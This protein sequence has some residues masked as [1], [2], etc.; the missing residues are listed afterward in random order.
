MKLV[1]ILI[2]TLFYSS[3]YGQTNLPAGK[4]SIGLSIDPAYS[5]RTLSKQ[6]DSS[7]ADIIYKSRN[8][9]EIA[10]PGYHFAITMRY[11]VNNILQ[12]ETGF[13]YANKGYRTKKQSTVFFPPDPGQP[14]YA[15]FKYNYNYIGIPIIVRALYGRPKL[16]F[17]TSLGV[18]SNLLLNV[19]TKSKYEYADGHNEHDIESSSYNY[20]KFDLA[21]MLGV[22]INYRMNNKLL[23]SI[24]PTFR[25]SV[26]PT[27]ETA[28][29]E[30]FWSVGVNA[31]LFY[32]L[33]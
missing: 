15:S 29:R 31:G 5:Y 20:K 33:R 9:R 25:Y 14:T 10:K 28:I 26:L 7:S 19:K 16:Q 27:T 12:I 8:E 6:V 30:R 1:C 18:A 32:K 21:P 24:E 3:L 4:Y 2:A 17:S 23:L 13:Q 11:Q 22:G